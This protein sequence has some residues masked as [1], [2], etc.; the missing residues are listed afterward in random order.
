[1]V[2]WLP[3]QL[4]VMPTRCC[5]KFHFNSAAPSFCTILSLHVKKKQ[6]LNLGE[7]VHR[8]YVLATARQLKEETQRTGKSAV[9]SL[10][11]PVL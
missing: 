2:T 10:G 1:M 9:L 3:S 6:E 8:R 5:G 7:L 11:A 4:P